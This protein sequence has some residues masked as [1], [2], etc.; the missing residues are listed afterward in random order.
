MLYK[1]L[2]D[3]PASLYDG[4]FEHMALSDGDV[5][6]ET[7]ARVRSGY[8]YQRTNVQKN[9]STCSPLKQAPISET[10]FS[11]FYGL[12]NY[13]CSASFTDAKNTFLG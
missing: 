6:K 1:P 7:S 8:I 9:S 12:I 10:G 4:T 11:L 3:V 5:Y 13:N 2:Q